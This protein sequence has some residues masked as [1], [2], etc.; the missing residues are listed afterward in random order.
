M[1]GSR[2]GFLDG[3]IRVSFFSGGRI[4]GQRHPDPV[5]FL[6]SKFDW[7]RIQTDFRGSDP[8]FFDG[9]IFLAGRIRVNSTHYK[10]GRT[11]LLLKCA[12]C[13]ASLDPFYIVIVTI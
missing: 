5:L 11:D 4:W 12:A 1:V 7:I 3:R 10:V 13:P 8:G 9:R 2:S 6:G